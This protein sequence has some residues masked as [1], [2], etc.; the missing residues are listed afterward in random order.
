M[1]WKFPF[2]LLHRVGPLLCGTTSSLCRLPIKDVPSL[3]RLLGFLPSTH[4]VPGS[5]PSAP[6]VC[7]PDFS[8][9]LTNPFLF[10][11]LFLISTPVSVF[12]AKLPAARTLDDLWI[13]Q[14]FERWGHYSLCPPPPLLFQAVSSFFF[15][16][17]STPHFYFPSFSI[18]CSLT[19]CQALSFLLWLDIL[20][21]LLTSF[22]HS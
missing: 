7:P 13:L 9:P 14:W 10:V 3:N 21:T 8:R 4:Q 5:G 20:G 16:T 2:G 1:V 19:N 12:L 11:A 17:L 6:L 15:Q 22:H 18:E